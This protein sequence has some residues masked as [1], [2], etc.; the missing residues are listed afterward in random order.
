MAADVD[1]GQGADQQGAQ[2][3]KIHTAHEPVADPGNQGQR[4]GMGNIRTDDFNR[5][6]LGIQKQQGSNPQRASPH[7]GQ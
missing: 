4:H 6:Q 5:W 3:L 7:R 1:A 2:Q